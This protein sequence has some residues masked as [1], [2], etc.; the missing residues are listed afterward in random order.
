M[1]NMQYLDSE[2]QFT[3]YAWHRLF[4]YIGWAKQNIR[5]VEG[6]KK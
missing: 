6:G 1:G 2:S 4:K 3:L 5:G